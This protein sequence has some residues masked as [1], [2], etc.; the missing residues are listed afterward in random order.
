MMISLEREVIGGLEVSEAVE[1]GSNDSA[2]MNGFGLR[3]AAA[4]DEVPKHRRKLSLDS[5]IGM[6]RLAC[7]ECVLTGVVVGERPPHPRHLGQRI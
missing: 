2:D 4:L 6:L 3:H 5:D 7:G 1:H